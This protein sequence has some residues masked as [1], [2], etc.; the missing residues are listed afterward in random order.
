[1]SDDVKV[2]GM[3]A[4]SGRWIFIILNIIINMCLGAVYAYSVFKKPLETQ[5]GVGATLGNLPFMIFLAVFAIFTF[6]TGKFIDKYG[7]RKIMMIGGVIVGIGWIL[8]MF[9]PH[10][11]IVTLTYGIIAGAGVGIVYGGPVAVA[12]R[13]FPDK[14]GLAVGLSLLGFGM[15]ALVT[16]P[17]AKYC[18]SL[19]GP[20]STCGI[21]GIGFLILIVILSSFMKFPAQG[22]KP[23]GWTPAAASG[24]STGKSFTLGE[25]VKT[26]S[27]YGL[28]LCY[29]IGT[30]AGLMAIG[31][32]ASVSGE[33]VG[34]DASMSATLV[35]IFAI[36]NGGGRPLF[37]WLTDKITPKYSAVISFI[38]IFIA[39]IFM[40]FAEQGSTMLYSLC[41][42]GF[43]LCLGG[44]LAIGPTATASFFGMDG[45][46]QKY[47]L[48][49]SAYGF[50]AI[51]G[52]IISGSAKDVFGSYLVAFKPTAVLAV[53]GLILAI[54]FIKPPVKK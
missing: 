20:L 43:W 37:G 31:M 18:I 33:V 49:F 26:S 36:F 24:V 35:A 50:G 14:K 1:M 25:M 39:S 41:F 21:M 51:I 46:A 11:Y 29:I 10:I 13:W 54:L 19:Y 15:S 30:T 34:L 3:P 9:A 48:M 2:F 17:F 5:F 27:F 4:K 8:T 16:A 23:E 38:I 12:A 28:W 42:F 47:G 7:P 44:W 6:L 45:Y 22:W 53:V 52:G 32:S 40:L